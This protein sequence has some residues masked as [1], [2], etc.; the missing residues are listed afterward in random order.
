MASSSPRKGVGTE[1]RWT[2]NE[3]KVSRGVL[4]SARPRTAS[5]GSP[6]SQERERN[7]ARANV[8]L[9][10]RADQAGG[11]LG[12]R[13]P[14]AA[15]RRR[16][17]LRVH[18]HDAA[19][20]ERLRHP[21]QVPGTQHAQDLPDRGRHRLY[22]DF[23]VQRFGKWRPS[24]EARRLGPL[25]LR[26]ET[27]LY[28]DGLTFDEA[29][30]VLQRLPMAESREAL[31]ALSLKI[32]RRTKRAVRRESERGHLRRRDGPSPIADGPLAVEQAERQALADRTFTRSR[33][34]LGR[35]P[36]PDRILLRLH[37]E[38]GLTL[39]EVAR[40]LRRRAEGPL[41]QAGRAARAA[42]GRARGRGHRRGG[43]A[44]AAIDAGLG[45]GPHD[46]RG[47]RALRLRTPGRIPSP[48]G[49][50]ERPGGRSIV[51]GRSHG[52]P[53]RAGCP[54]PE[55]IAAHAEGVSTRPRRRGLDEHIAGLRRLLRRLRRNAPVPP[56]EV[57][58]HAA[59]SRATRRHSLA[60][61]GLQDR[62]GPRPGRR[63]CGVPPH[64]AAQTT[65]RARHHPLVADLA[66]AMG[67]RRFVE[68][69]LTG[70]FQ[71]GRLVIL[72]SGEAPQ[73]L[74]AQSPRG[75]RR[76]GQDPGARRS[77]HLTRD[78]G[79]RSASPTSS[80]VT[81]A[82]PS[83]PSSR[84]PLRPPKTRAS[85]A[86]LPRPTSSGR[87]RARRARGHPEGP[88]GRGAGHRPER[89]AERGLVQPRPRPRGSAPRGRRPQGLGGLPPARRAPRAGP[90]RLAS[91][92][93]RCPRCASRRSKRTRPASRP[94]SSEGAAAVDRLADED[95]VA[96]ARLLRRRAPSRLGGGPPRRPSRR[97]PPP[98]A[99]ASPRRRP[100]PRHRRRDGPRR[101]SAPHRPPTRAPPRPTPCAP[102]PSATGP[103]S[104]AK[105][106]Y[107]L[108]EPS[109]S[110]FRAALGDL[111]AGGSPYVAWARLPGG[112]RL[113]LPSE[114]HAALAELARLDVS[115]GSP[116]LSQLLGRVRWL[117][118]LIH[119][120]RGELTTALERYPLPASSLPEARATS[121]ARPHA[122]LRSRKP[123]TSW[124]S[125]RAAWRERLRALALLGS[126]P[127]PHRRRHVDPGRCGPGSCRT[128]AIPGARSTSD[129][130]SWNRPRVRRVRP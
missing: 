46:G 119:G 66:E 8:P 35:L 15:G 109:C 17:R 1:P 20:R 60:A 124:A 11:G 110:A 14:R 41:P 34:A 123:S 59:D 28:R 115:R 2:L 26:L 92:S 91:T 114:P 113:P 16:R 100:P 49:E 27:L 106:L 57:E 93:R 52:T 24:A 70:G 55:Q 116:R 103:S 19:D 75:P 112:H 12:V 68:P 80:R 25:A 76:R 88:R 122:R 67:D 58:K 43:R 3:P 111:Q 37:V 94:R 81:W 83:R 107:D 64:D 53:G 108:Q 29:C 105:R 9:G 54:D 96:P 101:G 39:A 63:S 30:G 78:P 117:Q 4:S 121:R 98:R 47:A 31:Y 62:G 65:A 33:L 56:G 50:P 86:T 61:A 7:D 45:R 130:A 32:P 126:R 84:P 99:R 69:R 44:G 129:R 5:P 21:R 22:L 102:R 125:T 90:T 71:H 38:R 118:G 36:A 13:A 77:R 42:A 104:E 6:Q 120:H 127:E 85:G 82:P 73:G 87:S 89:P 40:L 10:T 128:K 95:A 18:R 48:R 79:R 74:D 97:E 51:T 72:R 23:Q